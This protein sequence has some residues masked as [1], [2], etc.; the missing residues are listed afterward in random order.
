VAAVVHYND[1][2]SQLGHT[3]LSEVVC[4]LVCEHTSQVALALAFIV[5]FDPHTPHVAIVSS[6]ARSSLHSLAMVT[7]CL[8]FF[9]L[10]ER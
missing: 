1:K 5:I 4:L 6:I 8:Q 7:N 3:L 10:P 2:R 9:K